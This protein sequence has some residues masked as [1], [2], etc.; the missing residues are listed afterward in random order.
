MSLSLWIG[1]CEMSANHL[2]PHSD[3][4]TTRTSDITPQK[5]AVILHKGNA[6]KQT[7]IQT[8][9]Q[10][11]GVDGQ[12]SLAALISLSLCSV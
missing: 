4:Q 7:V 10:L 3:D 9:R 8:V 5:S 11:E 6:G 2:A 12:I 1:G